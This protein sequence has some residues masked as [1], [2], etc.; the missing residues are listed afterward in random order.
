MREK[1]ES[2]IRTG[3]IIKDLRQQH[4]YTQEHLS[5]ILGVSVNHFSA[6]E[7]GASGA[8]LEVLRKLMDLFGVSSEYL[9]FG[10]SED[11]EELAQI[12]RKLKRLPPEQLKY[13]DSFLKILID[14]NKQNTERN[15]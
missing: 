13:V 11:T 3:K 15:R 4:S 12:V 5:E 10:E 7:R 6:I 2:N 9:L 14:V 1:K 8:S